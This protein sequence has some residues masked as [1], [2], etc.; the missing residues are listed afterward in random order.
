M[1]YFKITIAFTAIVFSLALLLETERTYSPQADLKLEA[2]ISYLTEDGT[3]CDLGEAWCQEFEQCFSS[4]IRSRYTNDQFDA[5]AFGTNADT[6][7]ELFNAFVDQGAS[8]SVSLT[9]SDYYEE[10]GQTV[11]DLWRIMDYGMRDMINWYCDDSSLFGDQLIA[12]LCVCR[13]LDRNGRYP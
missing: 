7:C 11:D 9:T 3:N 13:Q 1:K 8:C 10:T 5:L 4:G 6:V 12:N 2:F